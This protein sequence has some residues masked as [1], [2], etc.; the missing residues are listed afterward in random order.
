MWC[1]SAEG[2]HLLTKQPYTLTF[3]VQPYV[4]IEQM[5]CC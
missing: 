3:D 5:A 1:L 2:C 4:L